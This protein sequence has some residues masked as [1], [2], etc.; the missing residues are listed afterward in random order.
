MAKS[1]SENPRPEQLQTRCFICLGE[2]SPLQRTSCCKQLSHFE[3]CLKE[4]FRRQL[5]KREV[6]CPHCKQPVPTDTL[7]SLNLHLRPSGA[8]GRW[9]SAESWA[10]DTVRQWDETTGYW[11]D[12]AFCSI[13]AHRLP[14]GVNFF[15]DPE[16]RFFINTFD[17]LEGR[18]IEMFLGSTKKMAFQRDRKSVV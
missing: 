6:V 10:R 2:E 11:E 3:S 17:I 7:R 14:E 5:G 9:Q 1:F 15:R 13:M 12:P 18:Q 4:W 16:D 8:S